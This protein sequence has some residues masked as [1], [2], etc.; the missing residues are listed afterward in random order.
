M[1]WLVKSAPAQYVRACTFIEPVCFLLY[2]HNMTF[3]FLYKPPV[4]P[5]DCTI[6]Y[7]VNHELHTS[8]L[9]YRRFF[10]YAFALTFRKRCYTLSHPVV[11]F[12]VWDETRTVIYCREGRIPKDRIAW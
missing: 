11:A 2:K 9:L 7:Y 5:L 6:K 3:N 12:S 1:A 4:T 10:W 8:N